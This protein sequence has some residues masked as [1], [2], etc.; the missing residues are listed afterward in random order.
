MLSLRCEG[1]H[2]HVGFEDGNLTKKAELYSISLVKIVEGDWEDKTILKNNKLSKGSN[3]YETS[4]F[5]E[6]IG[7]CDPDRLFQNTFSVHDIELP[8][9]VPWESVVLRRTINR[10]IGGEV[11]EDYTMY[12]SKDNINRPFPG[13]IPKE[14]F[15]WDIQRESVLLNRMR[16]WKLPGS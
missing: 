1:N 9:R 4:R 5:I 7:T 14:G 10:K 16:T 15:D 6:G 12:L 3:P 13:Q 2:V 8:K 11:S